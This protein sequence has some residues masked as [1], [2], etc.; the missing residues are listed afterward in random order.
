MK[1]MKKHRVLTEKVA[2]A[3]I[4]FRGVVVEIKKVS[5]EEVEI[6]F[7]E[8]MEESELINYLERFGILKRKVVDPYLEPQLEVKKEEDNATA[9][10]RRKRK[11]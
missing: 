7:P 10:K 4:V 2:N 6:I 9:P 11:S 1:G 8:N 3:K 5:D